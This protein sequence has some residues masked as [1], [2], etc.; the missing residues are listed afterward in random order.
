[1]NMLVNDGLSVS[2][3][4]AT[5]TPTAAS[6][7]LLVRSE[8][9]V[10]FPLMVEVLEPVRAK[11]GTWVAA[12]RIP[13]SPKLYLSSPSGLR[14]AIKLIGVYPSRFTS[15]ATLPMRRSGNT[16]IPCSLVVSVFTMPHWLMVTLAPAKPFPALLPTEASVPLI[17]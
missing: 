17:M 3:T 9:I 7:A 14:L 1:M 2:R 11:R 13:S 16:T 10:I 12:L 8:S 4:I 15:T 5:L 6:G